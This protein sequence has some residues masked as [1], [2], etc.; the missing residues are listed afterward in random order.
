MYVARRMRSG[1][2]QSGLDFLGAGDRDHQ[3]LDFFFFFFGN[4]F[5]TAFLAFLTTF[6]AALTTRF[7][8]DFFFDFLA[9]I[10]P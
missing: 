7:V 9:I 6:L 4:T 5:L 3:R 10:C 2:E 1:P 8:T